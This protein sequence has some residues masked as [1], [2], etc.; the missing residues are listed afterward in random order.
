MR[1]TE[2]D[3]TRKVSR[4]R[5]HKGHLANPFFRGFAGVRLVVLTLLPIVLLACGSIQQTPSTV[6]DATAPSPLPS[7]TEEMKTDILSLVGMV[8]PLHD[9][10]I[11]EVDNAVSVEGIPCHEVYVGSPNEET[12]TTMA[13][14]AVDPVTHTIYALDRVSG[15]YERLDVVP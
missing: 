6:P 9:G 15:Q 12:T 7:L 13:L 8:Y 10:L 14:F 2:A 4:L 11:V 3:V 1:S 5:D